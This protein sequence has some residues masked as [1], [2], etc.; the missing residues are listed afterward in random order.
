MAILHKASK[1]YPL[2]SISWQNR[3]MKPTNPILALALG[4]ILAPA[5]G[6]QSARLETELF[7]QQRSATRIG[8]E[9]FLRLNSPQNKTNNSD[10]LDFS[11]SYSLRKSSIEGRFSGDLRFYLNNKATS[12]SLG[13]AYIRYKGENKSTY[14]LGRQKLKWHPNESF[15][16]LDHFQNTRGFRLMDIKNE[17]LTGFHYQTK[18]G[19]LKT[20][21]FLSYF[22]IP[23][24]NPSVKVED[25]K[26]V[27]N[28]DWYKRP[29]E[30]TV[31]SNQEVDIFYNAN[32][33]EYRDVIV[34]KSLGLRMSYDWSKE[35]TKGLISAFSIYKPERRLRINAEAYYDSALDQVVV[36]AN[37]IVNH[38][39]IHGVDIRQRFRNTETVLGLATVDPNARLGADFDSISIEIENN[40]TLQSEFFKVEPIYTRETYGHYSTMFKFDRSTL[41]LNYL[42]YFTDHEKGSDDFYSETTKW[43]SAAGLGGS[44]QINEWINSTVNLRYDLKRRD[45]L[46]NAQIILFP[47]RASTVTFGTELIRSPQ[48]NS[49]WSAYR[50]NDTFYMNVGY[51]F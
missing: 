9:K 37:P 35:D 33:P 38:H 10:W 20:E 24:L 5:F 4:L 36:N 48:T 12:P 23:G 44:F 18:D 45:N 46:L 3:C 16:Q 28:T 41:S 15:W 29:P 14:T 43:R 42:H 34:Q 25:G 30:R 27:S 31:I 51:I 22:Y 21:V 49:Y 39:I 2:A 13:E 26:V 6:Q 32:M 1:V 40:R 8:Y 17:G 50:A 7:D 19:S 47:W 11:H